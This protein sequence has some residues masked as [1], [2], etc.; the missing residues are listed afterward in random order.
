MGARRRAAAAGAGRC[1]HHAGSLGAR[2]SVAGRARTC[3]GGAA[4]PAAKGAA[5]RGVPRARR[6]RLRGGRAAGRRAA[7]HPQ[8]LRVRRHH[9]RQG[10]DAGGEGVR[11]AVR[12]AARPAWSSAIAARALLAR[13]D[14]SRQAARKPRIAARPRRERADAARRE[15]R[16]AMEVVGILLAKDLVGYACGA[17]EG[18]T[19][20]DLLHPP[21]FVPRTT[22]CDRLFREFQRKQDPLALVVD[23]YGRLAGL[24]TME[25]LLEELFGEIADEK[26]AR[27]VTLAELRPA[28]IVSAICLLVEMFF[29]AS[30]ISVISCDRIA[31]R[32]DARGGQPRGP[33]ARGLPRE[34]AALLA[35]TLFGTQL[36][37]VVS[38]VV[39]T[40]ALH[41]AV[42][43]RARELYLL[44]G[45][46]AGHGRLRRDRA[47]D[48]SASST[49][50]AMARQLV[51]PLWL[52]SKLFSPVVWLLTRLHDLGSLR[53]SGV[54]ERKLVTREELE[55]L[56]KGPAAARRRR[57]HRGRAAR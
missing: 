51:Y 25:D 24:V 10:D 3:V 20:Q 6:R 42:S 19:V 55:L 29:A 30:E 56:L 18:H 54:P 44:A 17:L 46:D 35:T 49:P 16:G 31:L 37:V 38:T 9:R 4:D 36:S 2:P 50:I 33:A 5:R 57:D 23:E 48:A 26:E 7:A 43:A 40:Y 21:L 41:Q 45:A 12:D 1:A 14:L 27:D 53:R 52:A 22:K 28:F 13:A 47:Q 8:R 32:K 39:M 11:A 34:Q 15:A